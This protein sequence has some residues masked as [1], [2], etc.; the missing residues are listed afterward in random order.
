MPVLKPIFFFVCLILI[1]SVVSAGSESTNIV[2][3]YIGGGG[4]I[5]AHHTAM[6]SSGDGKESNLNEGSAGSRVITGAG[7]SQYT[8]K[9]TIDASSSNVYDS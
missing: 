8:A 6:W 1:I 7:S 3:A 4:G 2:S 9:S 5:I